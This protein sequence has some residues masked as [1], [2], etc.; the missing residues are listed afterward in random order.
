MSAPAAPAG[1]LLPAAPP[2]AQT[3]GAIRW[4]S[5]LLPFVI[6]GVAAGVRAY[7]IDRSSY[8]SDEGNTWALMQR[9][10]AGIAAAAA[11]D[12]HPPGYYWLL[13]SWS[14]L[15]G[16]G[17]VA[18]RAFSALC[19]VLLVAAIWALG[20]SILAQE[21]DGTRR[22]LPIGAAWVAALL[23]F[24]VYYS[25]EA[26]MYMPLALL[27][28]LLF[29]ALIPLLPPARAGRRP[30]PLLLAYALAAA[31]G[32]WT[33]YSFPI[34]LA[35]AGLTWAIAW[36]RTRPWDGRALMGFAAANA[37]VLLSFAPWLPTALRQITT[38]P[39]G[40]ETVPW[41]EGGRLVLQTLLFGGLR[42]TP[43]PAWP[44]LL[45]AALLPVVGAWAL[46]HNRALVALLLW[47]GAPVL[48]M[49]A[50]GLFT[51]AFLKFLLVA[52][53]PWC[54]LLAASA[55]AAPPRARPLA[56]G[57]LAAGALALALLTLPAYVGDPA[58]RDNYKGIAAWLAAAADPAQD[59]VLLN[60]PGQ[61]DVWRLYDPGLPV[62]ALP[63]QRPPDAAALNA[64]LAA[65]TQGRR[66]VYALLWATDESD[67]EG[68]VE[69]WLNEHLYRGAEQWQGNVRLAHFLNAPALACRESAPGSGPIGVTS[70]CLPTFDSPT[71]A[72]G[73]PL[74]VE[75][76]WQAGAPPAAPLAVSLQLLDSRSQVAAQVDAPL[77]A[78][79]WP[80]GSRHSD[81]RA[82]L[83][84]AGTPPGNYRL[85]AALYDPATGVR[86][87]LSPDD[88]AL[89]LG[90]VSVSRPQ[91]PPPAALLPMAQRVERDLGPVRLLG[92]T[93][94]KAGF[95]HAPKTPV[96]PG[97]RLHL[98]LFWQAPS[99]LPA[100]WPA[101]L[102]FTL[103]LDDQQVTLPLAGGAYPTAQWQPAEVIRVEVEIPVT[104]A[105]VRARP[106]LTVAGDTIR[107]ARL[108]R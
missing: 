95:A 6:L 74:P 99:P 1:G 26:R 17:P 50:L 45:A 59:L 86:L 2:Q 94:H 80:A 102:T 81:R 54:L 97:D 57:A 53:A 105:G 9:S 34:V 64:E 22:W 14:G 108:P 32:L 23:P 60:A 89:D 67:P 28:A 68:L 87:P 36:L 58:A 44:W 8:W 85:I 24:Q 71:V 56:R 42:T 90:A 35:A 27:A 3:A 21:H 43:Q 4:V 20:R 88:A 40:G 47:L 103:S 92:Y 16:A 7:A 41:L 51:E 61:A 52:S 48:L 38:W 75:L 37:L 46:R 84:P 98:T 100:T 55:E 39:Q 13:K 65:A 73:Q 107:L 49:A 76:T 104:D 62:V 72:A 96:A 25:Q 82:L 70:V 83:V 31:A 77:P 5:R 66:S 18:L 11:A 30:L 91:Q 63:A 93:Q 106:V 19:G 101:D 10:W 79:T 29:L 12:I 33:H 69:A 78:D 15:F